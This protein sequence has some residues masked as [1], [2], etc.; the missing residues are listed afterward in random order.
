MQ[1]G[2]QGSFGKTEAPSGG[3]TSYKRRPDP[4]EIP[5]ILA[6]RASQPC[7]TQP[8][9]GA[10]G[11]RFSACQQHPARRWERCGEMAQ[12]TSKCLSC[13]STLGSFCRGGHGM[14]CPELAD[15]SLFLR[16]NSMKMQ[17]MLQVAV[18]FQCDHFIPFFGLVCMYL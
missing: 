9:G 10:R 18:E 15:S 4:W 12:M 8:A 11:P 17:P 6:V 13:L 7:P 5:A 1:A 2:T 16:W 14:S 3:F